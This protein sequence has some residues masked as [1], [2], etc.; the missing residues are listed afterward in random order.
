MTDKYIMSDTGEI[1]EVVDLRAWAQWFGEAD[2]HIE[3]TKVG[4]VEVSTVFLGLDYNFGD[5]G[6]PILFETMVF[7]GPLN[8]EQEREVPTVFLSIDHNFSGEGSPIFFETM[9]FGGPLN[10]EQERYETRAQAEAGH[11]FWVERV[12][13]AAAIAKAKKGTE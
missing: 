5:T 9:V 8:G 1:E 11:R 3:K 2:R 12:K 13:I 6:P 4:K 10:M 7:G